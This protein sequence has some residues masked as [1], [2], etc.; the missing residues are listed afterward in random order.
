MQSPKCAHIVP[1]SPE[2][3]LNLKQKISKKHL[4]IKAPENPHKKIHSS[5]LIQ[6]ITAIRKLSDLTIFCLKALESTFFSTNNISE[7][8]PPLEYLK[9]LDNTSGKFLSESIK[10]FENLIE[11]SF[12]ENLSKISFSIEF[13]NAAKLIIGDIEETPRIKG[14]RET[15]RFMTERSISVCNS[16]MEKIEEFKEEIK[17][18][19]DSLRNLDIDLNYDIGS[20]NGDNRDNDFLK[21]DFSKIKNNGKE[22]KYFFEN[23]IIGSDSDFNENFE[24]KNYFK[25]AKEISTGGDISQNSPRLSE[26]TVETLDRM[27][28]KMSFSS[29]GPENSKKSTV[30]KNKNKGEDENYFVSINNFTHLE[31]YEESKSTERLMVCLN[32][33]KNEGKKKK[34]EFCKPPLPNKKKDRKSVV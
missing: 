33:S 13:F 2:R 4:K 27:D 20:Y 28:T 19:P 9:I 18:A 12:V 32:N 26:L 1:N 23:T 11:K 10:N 5:R 15:D 16:I 31:G 3:L 7:Y 30:K 34:S 21:L 8:S 14:G 6:H 29:F 24:G 25:Y 17:F 22:E